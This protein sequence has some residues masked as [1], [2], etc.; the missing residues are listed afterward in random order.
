MK[1]VYICSPLRGD[2]EGNCKK[3]EQYCRW[4]AGSQGVV[5]YA[6]HVYF[7]RFLDDENAEERDLGIREGMFWL[8][9]CSELWVFGDVISSG[10]KA[11]IEYANE[12]AIPVRHINWSE[13]DESEYRS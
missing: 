3:A 4:A 1:R 9:L 2:V 10:M 6:P 8:S 5:P 11:E 7:T 13:I 12:H